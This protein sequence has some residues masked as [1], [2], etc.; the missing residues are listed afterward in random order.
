MSSAA[1]LEIHWRPTVVEVDLAA[2]VR[3]VDAVR[4]MLPPG[5]RL[6]AVLKAD[7]YGHGAVQLARACSQHH[8][9]MI[10]VS[11]LEEAMK[12]HEAAVDI[13]ILVLG[14]LTPDQ[15]EL[16][17]EYEMALGITGPEMLE[18]VAAVAT[19]R[20]RPVRVHLKLDSGMGRMGLVERDLT[21]AAAIITH[22][23]FVQLDALYSHFSTA[24]EPDSPHTARQVSR[25]RQMSERLR[26]LGVHAPLDH[27]ANSA[28]TLRS[29]V[30]PGNFVRVGMLLVGGEPLDSVKSGLEPVMRWTTKIAR[31]KR[32]EPGSPIGYGA[33]WTTP[34]ECDIA[35]VPVGYADGY[36]YLLSN[37]A[38]VLVRGQRAPIVGRVSMDLV[39]VDVTDVAGAA[40]GDEVVLLGRQGSETITAEE[41]AKRC[42]TI[43]YEILCGVGHR[44]PR[45]YVG[46]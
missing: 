13:P 19:K 16:A 21:E 9:A 26:E 37:N 39:T 42:G 22:A 31:M 43:S 34:R 12:L 46:G 36:P 10:A 18:S 38:D 40:L 44:V 6:I 30:D 25:F 35:T 32:M 20:R 5:S 14:P 7:G 45:T 33:T 17:A 1:D 41:L 2:F 4:A 3:N 23:P 8:V 27:M 11:L 29:I 28:A 24:S 15:I